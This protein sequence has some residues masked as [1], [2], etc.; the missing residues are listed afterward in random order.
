MGDEEKVEEME[1]EE[2]SGEGEAKPGGESSGGGLAASRIVK[3]LIYVVGGILAVFLMIGISYLVSKYVQERSYQKE[4]DIVVAPPPPPLAH[5]DLPVFQTA[6]TDEEPHFAKIT[7]SLGFE[8]NPELLNELIAR[9]VQMQHMVNIIMRGKK[10]E[11]LNSVEDSVALSEEIKAH[12][13]VILIA[14]KIREV[15]F[16]EFVVN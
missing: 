16:K 1:P 9:Q 11:D 15:Y 12:I 4:Q 14:G 13:N 6:T 3:I 5:Y 10:F 7:V 8:D 2:G